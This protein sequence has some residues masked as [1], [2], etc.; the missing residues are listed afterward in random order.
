MRYKIVSWH[1]LEWF[2]K[3]IQE[4]IEDGWIPVGG[5]SVTTT[6]S[7]SSGVSNNFYQAM[8]LPGKDKED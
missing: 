5:V 6:K 4:A 2:E 7:V 1:L 3:L 8:I